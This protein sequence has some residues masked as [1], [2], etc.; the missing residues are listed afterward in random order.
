VN[1]TVVGMA[2]WLQLVEVGRAEWMVP[3]KRVAGPDT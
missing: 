2:G 3:G 1:G